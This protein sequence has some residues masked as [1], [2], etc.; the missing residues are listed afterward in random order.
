[1][2]LKSVFHQRR[3]I[4]NKFNI[5]SYMKSM[6]LLKIEYDSF[7]IEIENERAKLALL[8]KFI[9]FKKLFSLFCE[10]V[11]SFFKSS[12]RKNK[13]EYYTY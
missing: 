12:Y 7:T 1:M 13:C 8:A 11:K 6:K 10:K 4:A 5:Y 2:I 3:Y 9:S